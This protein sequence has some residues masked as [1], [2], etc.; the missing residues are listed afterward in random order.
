[1]AS[2]IHLNRYYKRSRISEKQFR[3]FVM[4]FCFDDTAERIALEVSISR[5]A[6]LSLLAKMRQRILEWYAEEER[7]SGEIEVDESYGNVLA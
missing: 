1:M 7:M 2:S 3:V 6:T 4:H 5:R